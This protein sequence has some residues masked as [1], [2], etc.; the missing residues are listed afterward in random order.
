MPRW[1]K[2][3]YLY[4]ESIS[5]VFHV[6][7]RFQAG[8]VQRICLAL[9]ILHHDVEMKVAGGVEIELLTSVWSRVLMYLYI[10]S[11]PTFLLCGRRR[12][13]IFNNVEPS[14]LDPNSGHIELGDPGS[15]HPNR[16]NDLLRRA[17]P[18]LATSNPG[19]PSVNRRA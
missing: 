18:L 17:V 10:V 2:T 5:V 12:Q 7:S 16:G 11:R 13:V 15:I 9:Y 3:T 6:A 19:R 1:I 4:K 8:R 14:T